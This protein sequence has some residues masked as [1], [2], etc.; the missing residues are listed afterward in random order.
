MLSEPPTQRCLSQLSEWQVILIYKHILVDLI[1]LSHSNPFA[2][3]L[4][5]DFI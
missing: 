2:Q 5:F 4:L 1:M 3:R